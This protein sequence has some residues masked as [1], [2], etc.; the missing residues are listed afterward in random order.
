MTTIRKQRT[1]KTTSEL[2][3]LLEKKKAE[4]AK[5]EQLAFSGEIKER[6]DA[7]GIAELYKNIKKDLKDVGD[8]ALLSEIAKAA[9]VKRLTISQTPVAARKKKS[10]S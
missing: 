5:L 8:V 10:N 1:P 2:K 7:S 3:A 4:I 6:I 9:G